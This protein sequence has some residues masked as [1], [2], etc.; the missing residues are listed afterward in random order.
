MR[1]QRDQTIF[2]LCMIPAQV[3]RIKTS[4]A[5]Q[6]NQKHACPVDVLLTVVCSSA[7]SAWLSK[8]NGRGEEPLSSI[9]GERP[10][11][12]ERAHATAN[13]PRSGIPSERSD[14]KPQASPDLLAL[15]S[16]A[17]HRQNAGFF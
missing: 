17:T 6:T 16:D 5:A 7:S 15:R 1:A 14:S 9:V 3:L 8:S 4:K 10:L 2:E 11:R 12:T 13:A